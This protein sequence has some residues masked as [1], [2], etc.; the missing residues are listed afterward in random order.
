L[1][2][3]DDH[4]VVTLVAG[5]QKRPRAIGAHVAQRHRLDWIVE[6]GLG[7]PINLFRV[8]LW[9]SSRSS[10]FGGIRVPRVFGQRPA[11]VQHSDIEQ[12]EDMTM[13]QN[14]LDQF[15]ER[16]SAASNGRLGDLER[17]ISQL[18]EMLGTDQPPEMTTAHLIELQA[19]VEAAGRAI[20]EER[21]ARE[22]YSEFLGE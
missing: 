16:K 1:V 5:G 17:A 3:L 9:P 19:A 8:S 11:L 20:K 7:H 12:M 22:G 2:G 21:W 13:L 10:F 4:L 18:R 15:R 14:F 6:A